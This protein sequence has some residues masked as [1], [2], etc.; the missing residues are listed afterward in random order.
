M[1]QKIKTFLAVL[2]PNIKKKIKLPQIVAQKS[3]F[4]ILAYFGCHFL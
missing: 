1:L 3:H 2:I 4:S